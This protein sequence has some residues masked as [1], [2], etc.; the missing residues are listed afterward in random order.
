MIDIVLDNIIFSLQ[1]SGGISTLWGELLNK[2]IKENKTRNSFLEYC[3]HNEN[4]VRKKIDINEYQVLNKRDEFLKIERFRSPKLKDFKTKFIFCSSYYRVSSNKKAI[5]VTIVHDFTHEQYHKGLRKRIHTRQKH[6]AIKKANAI[7][8]I[9]ENT[10]KDLLYF[11]PETDPS[12]IKIIYNGVANH[13]YQINKELFWIDIKSE[14]KELE[15]KRCI[16]FVG[17]RVGYKNFDIA[18]KTFAL[19]SEDYHFLIIGEPLSGKEMLSLKQQLNPGSFSV[20]SRIDNDTLNKIY[21][22]SFLLLYPSSYEGFGIPVVESMKAGTPVIAFNATS[23]P[24]VAGN[25]GILIDK[26]DPENIKKEILKLENKDYYQ[27]VSAK[28][29]LQ[30]SKFSWDSTMQEYYEFF[31]ELGNFK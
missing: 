9:S 27:Q 22:K 10:K 11:F 30:S 18:L 4:I 25:A 21:N 28:G 31:K 6:N 26:L 1:K 3:Q 13:F 20:F 17:S 7:I 8:C 12:K 16:L 19:L 23:I 24:E 5:N 14:L 29:L 2:V 15:E